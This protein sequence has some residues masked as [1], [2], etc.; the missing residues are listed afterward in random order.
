MLGTS[1]SCIIDSNIGERKTEKE[2]KSG[3]GYILDVNMANIFWW[4]LKL[5]E[6]VGGKTGTLFG[7]D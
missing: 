6:S 7:Q 2:I 5:Q 4:V 3:P 1:S